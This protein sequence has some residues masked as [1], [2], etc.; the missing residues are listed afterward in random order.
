MTDS[1]RR[2]LLKFASLAG[3]S[4]LLPIELL[5][6]NPAGRKS[7]QQRVSR[8]VV[9]NATEAVAA[10]ASAGRNVTSEEMRIA[11]FA[12][13][14]LTDQRRPPLESRSADRVGGFAGHAFGRVYRA[15]TRGISPDG[16][17]GSVAHDEYRNRRHL[18][19]HV[20][21]ATPDCGRDS[22]HR[23]VGRLWCLFGCA[24]V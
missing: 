3:A 10:A 5:A 2:E 13:R 20:P 9:E 24:V 18:G 19:R 14:T 1:S 11:A 12:T 8:S 7:W 16:D 23:C 6:L 15:G 4:G 17:I 22:G 21:R